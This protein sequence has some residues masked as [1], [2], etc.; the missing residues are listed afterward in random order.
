MHKSDVL[1]IVSYQNLE[2]WLKESEL[3][4]SQAAQ[5]DAD[6]EMTRKQAEGSTQSQNSH[7]SACI[8]ALR[9]V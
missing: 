7:V 8:W 4:L 5:R 6:L 1:F 9:R 2:R 3:S